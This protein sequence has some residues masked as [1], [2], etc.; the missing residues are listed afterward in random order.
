MWFGKNVAED[1]WKCIFTYKLMANMA[2]IEWGISIMVFIHW[3]EKEIWDVEEAELENNAS[4]I[5]PP[6]I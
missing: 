3:T 2:K 5:S 6:K 1:I 4:I